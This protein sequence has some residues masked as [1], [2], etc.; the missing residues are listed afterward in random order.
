MRTCLILTSGI[1][2]WATIGRSAMAQENGKHRY[3]QAIEHIKTLPEPPAGFKW[4]VNPDFTD[5]FEGD[6]LDAEKWYDKSPYWKNGRPPA[7]FKAY[8]VSVE[9]G[10]LR[11]KNS[12]LNPTE[13]NDGKP[14]TKYSYAGGAV[15]SRSDQAWF[16]YYE[17]RMKASPTPMSSTFWLKNLPDTIRYVNE[18]GELIIEH[19]RQELDIIETMGTPTR[20]VN[21]NK[22]FNANTHYRVSVEGRYDPPQL[23]GPGPKDKRAAIEPTADAYH[24]Y[25]L[26][27]VDA[28]TLNF[29]Y[30]G[31]YLFTIHPATTYNPQPFARPMY[32]HMVTE[33][34]SWE[35]SLPTD[36]M[37]NDDTKN[38]THYDWVRSY[39]LVRE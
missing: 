39:I 21:W 1:L 4:A 35:P 20:F 16:G 24:T 18:N 17:I 6:R 31:R 14:G 3:L 22:Q 15:A 26:W 2:L 38:S 32:M 13:G 37:L 12:R 30:D 9:D 19:H 7:T 25:G 8:N 33:T 29:Y 36:D 23:D 28:N 27:W 10:Y 11:I 5:E 34:Y